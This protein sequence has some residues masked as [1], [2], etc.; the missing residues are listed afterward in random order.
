M[1]TITERVD[2]LETRVRGI[3]VDSAK[4]DARLEALVSS[5]NNL[6]WGVWA[7][8]VICVLALI[9]GAIGKDG[10]FA[11]RDA[12]ASVSTQ[13]YTGGTK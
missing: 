12:A 8:L 1:S 4:L 2:D 5:T 10:L 13:Q 6:K 3:E 11:V 9:Y 7:L